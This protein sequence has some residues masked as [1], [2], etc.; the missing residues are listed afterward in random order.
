MTTPSGVILAEELAAL[1]ARAQTGDQSSFA[2]LFAQFNSRICTYLARLVGNEDIGRDLAQDTF[3]AAWR[4]SAC[5]CS[6]KVASPS[7]R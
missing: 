1:V 7:A 6:S 5:Y 3:L 2:T 4:A